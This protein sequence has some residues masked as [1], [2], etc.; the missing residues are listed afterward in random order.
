MCCIP[1]SE[2]GN[3][4]SWPAAFDMY[5]PGYENTSLSDSDPA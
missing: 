4:S 2:T 5:R 3:N 1:D